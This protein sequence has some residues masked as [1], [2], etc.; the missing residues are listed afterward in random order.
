[1]LGLHQ[2]GNAAVAVGAVD[3]SR[4]GI[5]IGEEAIYTGLKSAKWPGR[6]E[7]MCK[8]P[9]NS[10]RWGGTQFSGNQ[11]IKICIGKI[12]RFKKKKDAQTG[13][14]KKKVILKW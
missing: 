12:F 3:L 13:I 1:M 14:L 5:Q 4:Y 8:N 10:Y 11:D 7:T 6:L 9:D 2:A